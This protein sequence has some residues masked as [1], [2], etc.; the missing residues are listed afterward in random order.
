ML[1]SVFRTTGLVIVAGILFGFLLRSHFT[2][3]SDG[4][5]II[6]TCTGH[7]TGQGDHN[8]IILFAP[9]K[10]TTDS[11][12]IAVFRGE[13][14]N[15]ALLWKSP[16][17]PVWDIFLSDIDSDGCDELALCLYK[18]EPHDPHK[19]NRLQIYSWEQDGVHA[20]WRGTYLSKPFVFVT[21]GDVSGDDTQELISVERG[22]Q[23]PDKLFLSVYRWNGFGFDLI[24]DTGLPGMPDTVRVFRCN[25]DSRPEIEL[26]IQKSTERYYLIDTFLK[27][28]G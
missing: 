8:S 25:G 3:E 1:T 22:R 2:G 23:H 20:L 17:A 6:K 9:V 16:P 10:G 28:R 15:R 27:K 12:Y 7:F 21:F 19:D 5:H 24:S 14:R 11:N 26:T 4:H 13:G 18:S